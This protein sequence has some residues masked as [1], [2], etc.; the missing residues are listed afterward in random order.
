M[1]VTKPNIGKCSVFQ[2]FLPEI[3][4]FAKIHNMLGSVSDAPLL[5]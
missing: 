3:N 1:A 5:F 2:C 4:F